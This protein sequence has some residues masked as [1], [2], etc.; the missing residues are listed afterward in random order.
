[1]SID[2]SQEGF[3][4]LLGRRAIVRGGQ[5]FHG[6]SGQ[7][8]GVTI[9]ES[10]LGRVATETARVETGSRLQDTDGP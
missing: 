2:S 3:D 1:M 6:R 7:V 8:D 10:H 4:L 9:L 5:T